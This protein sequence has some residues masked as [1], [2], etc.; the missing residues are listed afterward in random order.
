[1]ETFKIKP[2]CALPACGFILFRSFPE[3]NLELAEQVWQARK[4]ECKH[5]LTEA[6]QPLDLVL[7]KIAE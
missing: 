5:G 6:E 7:T 3:A 1:M 4:R 2:E